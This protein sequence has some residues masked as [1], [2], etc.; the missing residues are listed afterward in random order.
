MAAD[1]S[2]ALGAAHRIMAV[3]AL[4][5]AFAATFSSLLLAFEKHLRQRTA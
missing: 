3:T 2:E 5:I 4:L 1:K